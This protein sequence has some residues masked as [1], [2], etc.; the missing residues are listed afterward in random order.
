M[1]SNV[2]ERAIVKQ[3]V[4]KCLVADMLFSAHIAAFQEEISHIEHTH[5]NEK[6]GADKQEIHSCS[7]RFVRSTHIHHVIRYRQLPNEDVESACLNI[8]HVRRA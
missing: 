4:L 3:S 7:F 2:Y 8:Q 5:H 1:P 6:Q